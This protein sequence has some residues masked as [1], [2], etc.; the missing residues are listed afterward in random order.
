[1]KSKLRLDTRYYKQLKSLLIDILFSGE[2]LSDISK[3]HRQLD[4]KEIFLNTDDFNFR[5]TSD[6]MGKEI[7]SDPDLDN[8]LDKFLKELSRTPYT[9]KTTKGNKNE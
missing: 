8:V 3:K 9:K 2:K 1:M 4:G 6:R 7:A 5:V